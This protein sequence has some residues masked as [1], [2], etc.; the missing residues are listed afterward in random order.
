MASYNIVLLGDGGVGKTAWIRRM[1]TDTFQP[2]YFATVGTG[3]HPFGINT[4]Y[5]HIVLDFYDCAG[6][7]KYAPF[8]PDIKSDATLLMFDL[9]SRISYKNLKHWQERC[10]GEPVFVVGNKCDIKEE[11]IKVRPKFHKNYLALSAKR[12][13]TSDLLTPI[14]RVLTGYEDIEILDE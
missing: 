12:M 6:Q 11:N 8:I 14:L 13:T 9:T 3:V 7:E 10:K 2:H 5:G 1:R 4:N